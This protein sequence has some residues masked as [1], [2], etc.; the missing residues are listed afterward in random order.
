[1]EVDVWSRVKLHGHALDLV[2]YSSVTYVLTCCRPGVES[3]ALPAF[4]SPVLGWGGNLCH[5]LHPMTLHFGG[6]NIFLLPCFWI[7]LRSYGLIDQTGV[8]LTGRI[9][10]AYGKLSEGSNP[11]ETESTGL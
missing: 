5:H 3:T 8:L 11:A 1:M 10:Y 4:C 9:H 2:L 6:V 7:K